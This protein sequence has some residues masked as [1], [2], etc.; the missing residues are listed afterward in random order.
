MQSKHFVTAPASLTRFMT[1]TVAV[2]AL[3]V[4]VVAN[5]ALG[6]VAL[7][8]SGHLPSIGNSTTQHAA[9]KATYVEGQGEG[10]IGPALPAAAPRMLPNTN[11]YAGEGRLNVL[12]S[13][14]PTL[15]AHDQPYMGEGRL[16]VVRSTTLPSYD[17]PYMGEGRL[18]VRRQQETPA[19]GSCEQ[20]G[21]TLRHTR[22][23]PCN[24]RR[25]PPTATSCAPRAASAPGWARRVALPGS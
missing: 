16:N 22:P 6:G 21:A 18:N 8:T 24:C 17:Q 13:A 9:L 15:K 23:L 7:H 25:G 20:D 2:I 19:L 14:A 5:V 3:A 12:R 4:S 11:P 1:G 10:R